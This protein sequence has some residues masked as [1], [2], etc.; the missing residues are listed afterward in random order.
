MAFSSSFTLPTRF[1]V[2]ILCFIV[3]LLSFKIQ[4]IP[5]ESYP[6]Y[7]SFFN[8]LIKIGKQFFEPLYA[9]IPH[10]TL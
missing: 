8:P 9:T 5:A 6:R 4:A 2:V 1:I 3:V 10:M 7:S